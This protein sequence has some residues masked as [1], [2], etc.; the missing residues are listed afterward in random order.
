MTVPVLIPQKQDQLLPPEML[1]DENHPAN[2]EYL[3][4]VRRIE[5][6]LVYESTKVKPKHLAIIKAWAAGQ[7]QKIIAEQ[8]GISAQTVCR[9]VNTAQGQKIIAL[10]AHLVQLLEGPQEAQR[11]AMLWRIAQD[12]ELDSPRTAITA[13]E[14]INRMDLAHY[15]QQRDEMGN[16]PMVNITINAAE[17]PQTVLDQ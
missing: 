4:K 13:I 14:A 10:L 2:D 7:K 12:N 1:L 17:L 6:W 5:Q 16:T 9:V 3:K 8:Q 15:D 11:R